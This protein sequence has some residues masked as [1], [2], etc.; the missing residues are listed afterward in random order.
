[1]LDKIS[2]V[3]VE[4]TH[5]ANIGSVARAMKT[6][7]LCQLVLVKPYDFPSA[8]AKWLASGAVDILDKARVV[9]TLD[10]AISDCQLVL[11]TSARLRRLPWPMISANDAGRKAVEFAASGQN[12]AVVFGRESKGLTNE[13]LQICNHHIFI[14]ADEV[15]PVLN[16]ACA[17]QIIC[18][19]LRMAYLA[20]SG[21]TQYDPSS[22]FRMPVST[23]AWDEP[24]STY[25]EMQ[26]FYGHLEKTL[27]DIGFYDPNNSRQLLSRI[28]RIFQRT[29]LDKMEVNILR[30]ILSAVGKLKPKS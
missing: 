27:L 16:I 20:R 5:P 17:V 14:P 3:L 6:M 2:V 13:E 11:G 24:L 25:S 23:S 18:Y 28:A 26:G 4:T 29:R 15:Y 21:Q 1:M 7:G 22:L 9:D 19:E 8:R 30:G 12:V 10:E